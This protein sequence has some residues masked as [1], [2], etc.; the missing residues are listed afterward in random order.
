MV[1]IETVS[2]EFSHL[3]DNSGGGDWDQKIVVLLV[4]IIKRAK[5]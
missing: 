2:I 3:G 5:A 4:R 1:G